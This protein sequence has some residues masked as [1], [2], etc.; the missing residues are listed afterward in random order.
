MFS[1]WECRQIKCPFVL[2]IFPSIFEQRRVSQTA[3]SY[4]LSLHCYEFIYTL[5]DILSVCERYD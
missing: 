2:L 5:G 3:Q 4:V 1:G